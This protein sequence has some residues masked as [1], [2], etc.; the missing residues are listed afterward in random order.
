MHFY[1]AK[2]DH[3]IAIVVIDL[4][5]EYIQKLARNI[6]VYAT[7]E[8]VPKNVTSIAVVAQY[9]IDEE[10]LP[11]DKSISY[12]FIGYKIFIIPPS[13]SAVSLCVEDDESL[14]SVFEA[15]C[16]SEENTQ[17]MNIDPLHPDLNG[18]R[19]RHIA[20]IPLEELERFNF[21][22]L[23]E[24]E[25]LWFH[26]RA[27][28]AFESGGRVGELPNFFCYS[29]IIID[30]KQLRI[31]GV[32][33][34]DERLHAQFPLEGK[35]AG[36]TICIRVGD[37]TKESCDAI[38]NSSN[39]YLQKGSGVCGA[40][41]DGAGPQLKV[42]CK[43]QAHKYGGKLGVGE[44]VVTEGFNLKAKY[45]IHSVSPRCMFQWNDT[46]QKALFN[47][48]SEIFEIAQREGFES[49]AIPAMGIGKHYCDLDRCA[50]IAMS[51]LDEY[52]YRPDKKL[53]RIIFV[54]SDEAIA[55]KYLSRIDKIK[56]TS[57]M[58]IFPERSDVEEAVIKGIEN[59]HKTNLKWT[60]DFAWLS[61]APEYMINIFI[62]QS[63]EKLEPMPQIR[64][65]VSITDLIDSIALKRNL[66]KKFIKD[67]KRKDHRKEKID[68][69]LGDQ[70][71]AKVIIEVKNAVSKYGNGIDKDI[72]RICNALNHESSLEYGIF[73]FFANDDKRNILDVIDD[74]GIQAKEVSDQYSVALKVKSY[75]IPST[76]KDWSCAAVC[77]ILE[78]K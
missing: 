25:D 8:D 67:I 4:V 52:L 34:P 54:L 28:V 40:I 7:F 46:I 59:A 29:Q 50:I 63:L 21:R 55:N 70:E 73:A 36:V 47:A 72:Q 44:A 56:R 27:I 10:L 62:G 51:V 24:I 18:K 2:Y 64:F 77:F 32:M 13:K 75:V 43:A 39:V 23:E 68:I 53:K 42:A 71:N 12:I 15:L 30:E 74:I 45:I 66:E 26:E 61:L 20:D 16:A 5:A 37:I 35:F 60:N 49:I 22:D 48:Y 14:Q 69:L 19:F 17:V 1:F 76:L 31:I 9:P 57:Q 41:F 3:E 33:K 38:V 58:S 11:H 65:E 6:P 78:R